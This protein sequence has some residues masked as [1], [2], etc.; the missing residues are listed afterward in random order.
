MSCHRD[1]RPAAGAAAGDA[2]APREA[3]RE[4]GNPRRHARQDDA[5]EL[6]PTAR[7]AP[8]GM[9]PAVGRRQGDHLVVLDRPPAPV[10]LDLLP[11]A[12]RVQPIGHRPAVA[13]VAAF[14]RRSASAALV[15]VVRTSR[16]VQKADARERHHG[17]AAANRGSCDRCG[18][19]CA[20]RRSPPLPAVSAGVNSH[21]ISR[22]L[23]ARS[24]A[25]LRCSPRRACRAGAPW[26]RRRRPC[27][28]PPR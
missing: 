22:R 15:P 9:G 19:Q 5:A 10:G 12:L 6:R 2:T 24:A 28:A 14:D 11:A 16:R 20:A 17:D 23:V 25:G 3:G 18:R 8:A 27:G 21:A 13:L 26:P 7:V 1:H 4:L